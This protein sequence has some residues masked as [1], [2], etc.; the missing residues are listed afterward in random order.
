MIRKFKRN[1]KYKKT[2]QVQVLEADM[3]GQKSISNHEFNYFKEIQT[4]E[5]CSFIFS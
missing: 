5:K 2:A 4:R 3:I 1:Q